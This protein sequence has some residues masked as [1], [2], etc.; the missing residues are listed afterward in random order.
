MFNEE[1]PSETSR[2]VPGTMQ[3]A[4]GMTEPT[5]TYKLREIPEGL[6]LARGRGHAR[7]WMIASSVLRVSSPAS[8]CQQRV[9]SLI[10]LQEMRRWQVPLIYC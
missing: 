8:P 4:D 10:L 2:L 3:L 9:R 5:P 1:R 6:D 7:S